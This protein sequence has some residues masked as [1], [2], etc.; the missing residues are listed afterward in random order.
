MSLLGIDI[1]SSS[2][3]GIVFDTNGKELAR[4]T[5]SYTAI[6][7]GANK[8]EIDALYFKDAVFNVIR[9]LSDQVKDDPIESLAISSHGET[10]IPVDADGHPTANAIMNADNRAIEEAEWWEKSF[11][12]ERIYS[13]AG[14]PLHAMF[15]LNKIIW[16][17]K[18]DPELF[19]RTARFLSVGDFILVQLGLP[20]YTDYSLASRTMAFDINR[21]DWSE[22]IL[23]HCDIPKDKLGIPVPSGT[24]AGRLSKTIADSLG[25][26]EGAAV[27]LGGHDQPCGALGAGA[28]ANGDVFDSAGS[29]ECMVA[30]TDAPM[31]SA[32]A[33]NYNLNSYCHVVPGKFVTL[34]F[35][36]AGLISGWFVDQF[37]YE[38]K[39]LAEKQNKTVYQ[40]LEQKVKELVPGPSGINITPHLVGAC[41]PSWDVRATTIFAGIT[42]GT[43]K[44]HL[45]KAVFEGIA[46]E[47]ALNVEALEEVM[48]D[49]I[50]MSIAGGNS[51]IPF[52]VQ[53]RS[54]LTGKEIQ[55]L[56]TD[57]AVCL[58]AAILAGIAIGKYEN[59]S[60]AASKLVEID[61]SFQP[62]EKNRNIYDQ[63]LKR[64]KVI[65]PSLAPYRE[66]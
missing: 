47:L 19:N 59:A 39:M 60:D 7:I 25:L 14:V 24:L 34:A 45:Y 8:V 18:N 12:R 3:K 15:S 17:R 38:E 55:V 37:C 16:L 35:F 51:R 48:G 56:K 30:I 20:P 50:A 43:T 57:E 28:V 31:N 54:D 13:I 41:T 27:A 33:L 64:Y 65:Y 2:C 66:I 4:A 36:P 21:L 61:T 53:L 29:Y 22:E 42:P 5:H 10:I 32:K 6:N 1:G 26:K 44:H 11:G 46:C 63:Q 49:F 40:V 62:N 58:G 23:S 52:T 9:L